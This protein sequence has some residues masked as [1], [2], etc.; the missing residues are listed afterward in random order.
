MA[1]FFLGLFILSVFLFGTLPG[2]A[3]ASQDSYYMTG[4]ELEEFCNSKYDTEYGYCAGFVTAIADV[5]LAQNVEGLSSCNHISAK[6]EQLIENIRH[7]MEINPETRTQLA[8]VVV[9]RTLAHGFPCLSS[10]N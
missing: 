2:S 8:R 6:S 9:A 10:G 1:K 4:V 7:F 3:K 5:M